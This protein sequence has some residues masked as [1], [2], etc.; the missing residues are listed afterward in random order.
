M[1]RRTIIAAAAVLPVTGAVALTRPADPATATGRLD[2]F[3]RL[4]A[5]LDNREMAKLE[6]FMRSLSLSA[7]RGVAS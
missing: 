6:T 2:E 3:Q 5:E 1:D 7:S 4:L